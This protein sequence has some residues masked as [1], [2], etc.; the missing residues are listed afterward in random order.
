MAF[1]QGN[2]LDPKPDGSVTVFFAKRGKVP[3][4]RCHKGKK[5]NHRSQHLCRRS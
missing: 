4:E 2:E 1:E 3:G 5:P